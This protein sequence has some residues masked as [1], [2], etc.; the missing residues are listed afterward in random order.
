MGMFSEIHA[1]CEARGLQRSLIVAIE[2]NNSEIIAFCKEYIY[3]LYQNAL[4]E[5]WSTELELSENNKKIQSFFKDLTN[6]K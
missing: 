5:S 4:S 1:E 2:S 3:P 6:Q